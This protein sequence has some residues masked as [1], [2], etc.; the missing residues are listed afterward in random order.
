MFCTFIFAVLLPKI[1]FSYTGDQLQRYCVSDIS[2]SS[3]VAYN[4]YFL[5]AWLNK[6]D[7]SFIVCLSKPY[8]FDA[9]RR[10]LSSAL[11]SAYL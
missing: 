9:H 11:L 1:L 6:A 2:Y 10:Y 5:M 3:Q 8:S 7:F 4:C